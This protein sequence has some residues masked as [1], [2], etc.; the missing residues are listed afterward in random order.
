MSRSVRK[1]RPGDVPDMSRVLIASIT[2]LCAQDHNN[3]PQA[4]AAWTTN[5]TEAG[6]RQMLDAFDTELYVA[7]RENRVVAVGGLSG[8]D[9]ILNYVD[10][11]HRRTGAS[12][13]LLDA[14]ERVLEDRGIHV[15]RLTSTVTARDFYLSQGWVEDGPPRDGRFIAAFP[16]RK[17]LRG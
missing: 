10:P 1:A 14:M 15:A 4:I 17:V 12:R 8:D 5:K 3:D 7:E 11:A 13:A 9:I 2:E 6:L 16:M